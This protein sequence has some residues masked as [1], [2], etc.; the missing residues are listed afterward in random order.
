MKHLNHNIAAERGRTTARSPLRIARKRIVIALCAALALLLLLSWSSCLAAP[1]PAVA[2]QSGGKVLVVV[3]DRIG[4]ND[5]TPAT[6]P[7]MMKLMAK[8][9]FSLMNARVKYDA[10]GLGSYLVIGAGGRALGG[11]N[12]GL[13]F[14]FDERLRT[15]DNGSI[16]AG[17]IYDARTGL[18][19]P[20]TDV[21][22]LYI[23]EMI[24]KSD[25]PQAS[26][27]PGLMGQT[28][29]DGHKKIAVVG[30]ADSLIPTSPVEIPPVAGQQALQPT[31]GIELAQT[32]A[33]GGRSAYSLSSFIHR[34]VQTIAM[35]DRGAV[36]GGDV[37]ESLVGPYTKR[38]GVKTDF[39]ALERQIAALLPSTDVTVVDT[40]E[41]S[42]VDEQSDFYTDHALARARASALRD[43]DRSLGRMAAMLDLNKDLL[44]V[45]TPTPTRRM[46]LKGELLTPLVVAGKGFDKG[47]QLHSPTTRRTGLV[48][49]YDIAPTIIGFEGLKAPSEMDG[50]AVTPAGSS[51]DLAGLTEFRDNAVSASN[52]RKVMVRVFVITS[53][54]IIGLFFLVILAREDLIRRHPY[55]WSIALLAL[56]AGPFV[57]LAVPAIG[58][59]PQ[60]LLVTVAVCASIIL[61]GLALLLRDRQPDAEGTRIS[62]VL[63]KP[64]MALSGF[65][66]L[67]IMLDIILGSPLMSFSAFGSDA[68]LGDRYYGIGNLY[69]GFAIGTAVV[70]TCVAVQLRDKGLLSRLHMD[71]P[72]KR[73]TFAAVVLGVTTLI[74]GFSKFGANVGGLI[75]A[76]LAALVTV[77]RLEGKP[78]TVK[79]VAIVI[80]ILVVCVGGLVLVDALMPGSASHAGRAISK[81]GGN[82]VGA[83]FSQVSRKLATNWML[84]FTSIWRLLLLFG[85]I[86]WL[87]FNWRFGVLKFVKRNYPYLNAGFWGLVVGLIASW[88]FND[89]G[90]EATS[91]ISVFLFVPYFLMLVPWVRKARRT[92]EVS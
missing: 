79:R 60:A 42:R 35:D 25:T 4:L 72:W 43:S 14:N 74:I 71:Q 45:C 59:V 65:T 29:R 34:E 27:T 75:A 85:V 1:A 2:D 50:R 66:L 26:S 73:Y 67:L 84:T 89:S 33:T 81:I 91:A 11:L 92:T 10:Y 49:N 31:A 20:S 44:I 63:L 19:A 30:N 70:F 7:N 40:G 15:S 16:K 82:G 39:A 62:A 5:I 90:I 23:E 17:D 77:L 46:I 61:G 48:S 53:M 3:I 24:K 78:M 64:V 8:G 57:W 6:T 32:P 56:L 21:V 88:I 22:N 68:V 47:G 76:L 12:I 54:C 28:L 36:P 13:A 18:N 80:V 51:T 41:T 9:S 86:A 52:S 83:A 38:N 87:V 37:G 69:M 58:S 55:F